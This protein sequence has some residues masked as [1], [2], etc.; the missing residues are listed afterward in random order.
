M[1]EITLESLNKRIEALEALMGA[2]QSQTADNPS[3]IRPAAG[4]DWR[5]AI[6]MFTD[7]EFHQQ[8]IDAGRAI[9]EAER[10]EARREAQQ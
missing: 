4:Q 8:V 1:N 9:R 10:E 3:I 6:G 7:L 5:S 2:R